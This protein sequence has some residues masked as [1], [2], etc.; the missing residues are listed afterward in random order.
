MTVRVLDGNVTF[1]CD[2][3]QVA[4]PAGSTVL[5]Q[6]NRPYRWHPHEFVRLLVF[7]SPAWTPEQH[8]NVPE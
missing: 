6:T 8:E 4:L 7:S 1:E 5:V 2:G 3:E